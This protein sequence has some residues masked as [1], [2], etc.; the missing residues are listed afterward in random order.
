[1]YEFNW[2]NSIILYIHH[3]YVRM[4]SNMF[5]NIHHDL[6]I[7]KKLKICTHDEEV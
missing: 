3:S 7:I 6:K 5:L 1:M 4:H 2:W